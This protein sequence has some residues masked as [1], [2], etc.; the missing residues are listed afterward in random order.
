[1]AGDDHAGKQGVPD[2]TAEPRP[3]EAGTSPAEMTPSP[4]LAEW[5]A[6]DAR[7]GLNEVG[8]VPEKEPEDYPHEPILHEYAGGAESSPLSGPAEAG[9]GATA[10]VSAAPMAPSRASLWPVAAGLVV[11]AVIGA[12]SAYYVYA[13]A[14]P[15]DG[16]DG[17]VAT[18]AGQVEALNKRPDPAGDVSSLKASVA[19]LS[20]KLAAVERLAQAKA[21]EPA[22]ASAPA[23]ASPPPA[24]ASDLAQKLAALQASFEAMQQRS[25]SAS[26]L[27]A[28]Q[29]KLAAVAASVAEVQKQA[30]TVRPD[31]QALQSNLQALQSGQQSLQ[32]GQQ[33]LQGGQQ[34][35]QSGQKVLEGKVGSPALAVV[36][37]SLVQQIS[38]GL[39]FVAQVNALDAIGVDPARIAILRQF[40]DSGVPTA[41][42]LGAKFEPL[43]EG[44]LAAGN[45]APSDAGFWDR[46]K[47]GA[48]GLVS[49]RRVDAVA[50][51]DVASHVARIRADLGR[52][53]VVDAVKTWALLPADAKAKPEAAS[54]GALAKTHAEAVTAADAIEHDAIAALAVKKS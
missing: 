47:N 53:D 24:G 18:L 3:A 16:L 4:A 21:A 54:W 25:A 38:R 41:A 11:G 10:A 5:T 1:M 43:T 8:A 26:D 9:S 13:N 48:S 29:G 19:D 30:S 37:D 39:P 40:A 35:L 12:G 17:Q 52:N 51:D 27:A 45:K 15:T 50:G 20:D 42:A 46:L 7:G 2:P 6:S 31:L 28:A 22:A 44:L 14:H 36:A 34:T 32:N 49:V 23:A 33:T